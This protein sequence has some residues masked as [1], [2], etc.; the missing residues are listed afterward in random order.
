M[1]EILEGCSLKLVSMNVDSITYYKYYSA[2]AC[3][4]SSDI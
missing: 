3:H 2:F 4:K 1:R